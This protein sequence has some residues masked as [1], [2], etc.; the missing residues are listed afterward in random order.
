MWMAGGAA[1]NF[2]IGIGAS[3]PAFHVRSLPIGSSGV[4]SV[5]SKA[6]A[7]P[8]LDV[9][10]KRALSF[11]SFRV[12]RRLQ[13]GLERVPVEHRGS[14]A[15]R[16][17]RAANGSPCVDAQSRSAQRTSVA[18]PPVLRTED[19]D[20][21]LGRVGVGNH[22]VLVQ[23]VAGLLYLHV[24]GHRGDDRLVD[25]L[26]A[27]LLDYVGDELGEHHGRRDDSVPVAQDQRVDTLV[28]QS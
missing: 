26:L 11:Y 7:S 28:L 12:T 6:T 17:K 4:V 5:E 3:L 10:S 18:R 15:L 21:K 23:V 20:G 22:S 24:A 1:G 19:L 27:I 14:L 25:A 2:R 13:R 16:S 8:Y 9:R